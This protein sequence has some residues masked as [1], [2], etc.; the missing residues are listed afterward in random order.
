[1]INFITWAGE[2]AWIGELEKFKTMADQD[3]RHS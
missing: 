2:S 1:M 3:G